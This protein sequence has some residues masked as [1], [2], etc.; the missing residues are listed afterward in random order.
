MPAE[1]QYD[2]PKPIMILGRPNDLQSESDLREFAECFF[3]KHMS[4]A[5]SHKEDGFVADGTSIDPN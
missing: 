1:P 4:A 2:P 5:E 3:A